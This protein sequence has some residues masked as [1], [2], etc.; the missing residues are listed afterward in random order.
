MQMP[1]VR[2]AFD[3]E[4]RGRMIA[5]A[6]EQNRSFCSVSNRPVNDVCGESQNLKYGVLHLVHEASNL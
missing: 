5:I 4:A 2:A 1:S 6:A 3:Q